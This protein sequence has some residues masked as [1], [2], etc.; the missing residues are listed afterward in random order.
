MLVLYDPTLD[1]LTLYWY[2]ESNILM[3]WYYDVHAGKEY[4]DTGISYYPN[5]HTLRREMSKDLEIIHGD[6]ET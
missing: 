6:G 5:M 2:N 3:Y 1:G 4:I